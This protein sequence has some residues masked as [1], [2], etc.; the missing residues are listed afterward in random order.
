M[1]GNRKM[2]RLILALLLS[3]TAAVAA[4]AEDFPYGDTLRFTV[5]RDGEPIGSHVLSFRHE[6]DKRI[7]STAIDF[8][9]KVLGVTA[10]RYTHRG[11]E[12]WSGGTLQSL[13]A[14]T[15]DNGKQY[16]VTA[17]HQG[18]PL[19]VVRESSDTL[20]KTM[21][22]DQG[23]QKPE[24]VRETLPASVMPSTHWNVNQ[25]KQSSL[26]NTQYGTLS[27][28]EIKPMGRETVKTASGTIEATHYSYT[29]DITMDQWYDDRGRWV[30]AAFKAFD[31]S[32]IEYILQE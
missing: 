27:R 20:V 7:V 12:V 13:D 14:R 8:S 10:Y 19:V 15:D 24:T 31:G 9:V 23:L 21:L 5:Y 28:T 26:L 29:G 18:G 3:A 25:V 4:N 16:K 6:G 11:D 17:R 30:K 22:N 2:R 1:Q 32:T